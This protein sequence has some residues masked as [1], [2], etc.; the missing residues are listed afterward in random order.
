MLHENCKFMHRLLIDASCCK[1]L[2]KNCKLMS[3]Y[4]ALHLSVTYLPIMPPTSH[5]D[6]QELQ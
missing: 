1:F 3:N 2:G 5:Q 4:A 6:S